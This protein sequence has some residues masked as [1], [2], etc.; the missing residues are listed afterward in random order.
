[1]RLSW[2]GGAG[3]RGRGAGPHP[4]R[5]RDRARAPRLLAIRA[6]HLCSVALLVT[7]PFA[8]RPPN[9]AQVEARADAAVP[10]VITTGGTYSGQWESRDYRTPVVS[11]RTSA[12]VIIENSLLRG[13]GHLIE[14]AGRHYG[15]VTI[16]NVRGEGITPTVARQFAGRFLYANTYTSVTIENSTITG[17]SGIYLQDSAAGATVRIVGNRAHNIDGRLSD[18]AGGFSGQYFAQ[19]VQFNRGN[20]LVNSEVAWNEVINEPYES[21]VEDVISLFATSGRPDDP[22]RIHNNLIWGAYPADPARDS[23]SGGGIMLGD[24]GGAYLHAY[25]NHVISTSNYGIAIAGGHDNAVFNNRVVSCG[26]L[27]DGTPIASQNVGI[28]IWN[29]E[30]ARSFAANTGS[31]NRI[32]WT[33]HD[34]GRNDSWV[35]DASSWERNLALPPDG[36]L[37]CSSESAELALWANKVEAAGRTVGLL[38]S[39]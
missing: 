25:E 22:I 4:A 18:G 8:C 14:M 31:G 27:P 20:G 7:L 10:L 5:V 11:I 32:G 38:D 26:R 29:T 13:P 16:R 2:S 21:R 17:T 36:P 39:P 6:V 34:L 37:P 33:H 19:F 28:Y 1:M 23:F 30:R 35:P 12:P 3:R 15:N 9:N 24:H